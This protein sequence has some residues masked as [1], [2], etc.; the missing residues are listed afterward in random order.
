MAKRKNIKGKGRPPKYVLDNKQREIV[1]LSYNKANHQYYLTFSDPREYLGTSLDIAIQKFQEIKGYE[2][3][4][5]EAKVEQQHKN[6]IYNKAVELL[7]CDPVFQEIIENKAKEEIGKVIFKDDYTSDDHTI[8][9]LLR[10]STVS[11]LL[12]NI[13]AGLKEHIIS[14]FMQA[15]NND[16]RFSSRSLKF[17][18]DKI[19]KALDTQMNRYIFAHGDFNY[20]EEI[21]KIVRNNFVEQAKRFFYEEN[22]LQ[23]AWEVAYDLILSN[24]IDA[25]AKTGIKELA[26]LQ[27]CQVDYTKYSPFT[28]EMPLPWWLVGKIYDHNV[29][30]QK[31]SNIRHDTNKALW[32][33]IGAYVGYLKSID[34][35]A[36]IHL[37]EA[38]VYDY[39]S[40]DGISKFYDEKI[41]QAIKNELEGRKSWWFPT[42][43]KER[44]NIIKKIASE[45]QNLGYGQCTH[46]ISIIEDICKNNTNSL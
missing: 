8:K 6:D 34:Q 46:L 16:P 2:K 23:L 18:E 35:I 14:D 37:L 11:K 42:N 32:N 31:H 20:N 30:K 26:Y 45:V 12:S 22:K 29:S 41:W 5:D 27:M 36:K 44:I 17:I 21:C 3:L 43:P 10:N 9:Y 40:L 7:N 33:C 15:I 28:V 39:S 13:L 25:A 24:P 4:N 38:V 19:S 1:G